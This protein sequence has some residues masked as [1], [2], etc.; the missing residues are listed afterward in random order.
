VLVPDGVGFGDDAHGDAA[1][2]FVRNAYRHGKPVG[3]CGSGA[4][5]VAA[6]VP[7]GIDTAA[8]SDTGVVRDRGV[9]TAPT[10][11]AAFTDAFVEALAAHRH[12]LRPAPRA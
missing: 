4:Q 5:V 12:P 2:R 9:V 1:R 8:G 6:L 10:A 7:D 3:G 11:S